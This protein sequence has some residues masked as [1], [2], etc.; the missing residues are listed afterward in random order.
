MDLQ[1]RPRCFCQVS[2]V[3]M[4]G[5]SYPLRPPSHGMPSWKASHD[6]LQVG[7][8]MYRRQLSIYWQNV[9]KA[10]GGVNPPHGSSSSRLSVFLG[11]RG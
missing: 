9:T 8:C 6:G 2:Q 10:I 3:Q 1:P 11:C 7:L 4:Q 5:Q